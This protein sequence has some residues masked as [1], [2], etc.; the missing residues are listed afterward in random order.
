MKN[1]HILPTQKPSRLLKNTQYNTFWLRTDYLDREV[2]R[3]VVKLQYQNINITSD[4]EKPKLFDWIFFHKYDEKQVLQ[5]RN[6]RELESALAENCKKI[7]LTTDIDLIKDGVQAIP[8]EFLEWFVKNPSCE[9]VEVEDWHNKFLSCCRSKEECYCN[10]KRIIIPQEEP[11]Q[12]L[13]VRLK[14]SLKQFN[15]TLQ[16]AI[17]IDYSKLKQI[18][19]GNRSIIELQSFKEESKQ[20]E[21]DWSGFPKSTQEKVGFKPKQETLEEAAKDFIENTMKYSFNSLETKTFANR[22]L[23]CVDFGA[24]WQEKRMYSEEDLRLAFIAGRNF[25]VGEQKSWN[26]YNKFTGNQQPNKELTFEEWFEQFKKK[27]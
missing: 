25:E 7:I 23:K 16:E 18:G 8:D 11:K 20:V 15:L 13:S 2:K 12:E 26:T 3:G 6:G 22:L 1:I 14:N 4:E 27:Q 19:F 9:E 10:K 17:N 5:I 24:K 21:I